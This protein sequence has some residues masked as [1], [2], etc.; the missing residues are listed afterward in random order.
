MAKPAQNRRNF[1]TPDD[2]AKSPSPSVHKYIINQFVRIARKERLDYDTFTY[3]CRRARQRLGFRKPKREKTLPQLLTETDLSLFYGAISECGNIQH[4]IMLKL[5]YV[6][7]VRVSE[8]INIK[9]SD[10]DAGQ[11]KIFIRQGKG[12]KDRYILFPNN[13]CLTLRTYLGAHPNNIYLFESRHH[14]KYTPRRI[15][16]IVKKYSTEAGNDQHVHPHLFR[17]QLLT[18]LTSRGLSDA[19]IQLISGHASKHALKIYQHLSLDA[20]TDAY[21]AAVRDIKW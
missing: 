4:E 13:F 7:G 11:C 2:N 16:Q 6:T 14:T 9:V 10:V 12:D 20:V 18:F 21:Q 8:L 1:V 19:Q 15:Q 3:C 17:H 5:L